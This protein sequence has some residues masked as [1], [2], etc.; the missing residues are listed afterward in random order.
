MKKQKH[1]FTL[2]ELLVGVLIIG[3]LAAVAVPQYQKAV[4]K[5]RAMQA[6]VIVKAIGD[7]QELYY[8]ANG[9]YT[10]NLEDLNI[11]VP[12]EEY[13]YGTRTRK[14]TDYFDFGTK[15]SLSENIVGISQRLNDSATRAYYEIIRFGKDSNLYCRIAS[16]NDPQ[17][18]CQTLSGGNNTIIDEKTYYIIQYRN[19]YFFL[20]SSFCLA[21]G[22]PCLAAAT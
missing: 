16:L 8:L 19:F 21:I 12:G 13:Q 20:L 9:A 10:E 11:D 6:V 2:I 1:G 15:S 14:K 22:S 3:I 4:E 5:A 18:V 17:Q 7:A